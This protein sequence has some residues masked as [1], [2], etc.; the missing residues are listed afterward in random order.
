MIFRPHTKNLHLSRESGVSE[1]RNCRRRESKCKTTAQQNYTFRNDM[2]RDNELHKYR[3]ARLLRTTLNADIEV[4]RTKPAEPAWPTR[5]T[6]PRLIRTIIHIPDKNAPTNVS[7]L[8]GYLCVY[9]KLHIPGLCVPKWAMVVGNGS[10]FTLKWRQ[11]KEP[12]FP[13]I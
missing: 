6:Q 4:T 11:W 13:M 3:G 7:V 10:S 12:F 1:N 5:Y 8:S 9:I 2:K